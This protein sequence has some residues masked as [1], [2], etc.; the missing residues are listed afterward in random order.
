[1]IHLLKF[2]IKA[3]L[4]IS[5]SFIQISYAD[6]DDPIGVQEKDFVIPAEEPESCLRN[7][8]NPCQVTTGDRPR[9]LMWGGNQWEIDRYSVAEINKEGLWNFY[10]GMVVVKS[11]KKLKVHTPFADIHLGNSKV[12]I[13]VL[14]DRV[15][16]MSLMGEGV[17]VIPRLNKD[18]QFLVP[19][20]QNWY[21]GIGL[22]GQEY[23]VPTVIDLHA[24]AKVRAKFFMDHRLGFVKELER[25][26]STV[27]W[28]TVLA[29]KMHREMYGRKVASLRQV[30]KEMIL[31]KKRGI[32][33][34]KFLRELF[35]KKMQYDY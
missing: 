16:V 18:E 26:A 35:L 21:A 19:G 20:F 32:R 34:N 29:S 15:R 3:S 33:Y 1:M 31:R 22:T 4:F 24:F 25:M 12:L 7:Q 14:E 27:K 6:F 11:K 2:F 28:A 5:F 10:Q 23:G 13:H 17:K 9:F 30:N 8:I